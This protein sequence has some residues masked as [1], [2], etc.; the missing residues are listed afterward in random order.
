[1]EDAK[2]TEPPDS[3]HPPTNTAVDTP[4][5]HESTTTDLPVQPVSN[6]NDGE[7]ADEASSESHHTSNTEQEPSDIPPSADA[8][9][10]P[11]QSKKMTKKQIIA[12]MLAL[13]IA[14]F[15]AALDMSIVATAMPTIATQFHASE[16]GYSWIAS[17]YL[18]GNATCMPLWGKLSDIWGRKPIILL[19]NFLFLVSS[20][21]CAL[22]PNL[23]TL[24][25]GRAIQGVGGGGLIIL[26][27][28]CVGDLF[29]VRERPLYYAMF[30]MTWAVAGSFGP[31]VGGL[32]TE[33]VNWR[34]CFYVNLPF[35]GFSFATLFF[36][37]KIETPKTPL[38]AGLR[39]ID[40][41]GT[42]TII[43]GTLMV[44]FGLEFGGITFP[45][46]SATVICLL[47]FGLI[48][49][50]LFVVNE[51]RAKYPI[52]PMSLFRD[53]SNIFTLLVTWSHA[54]VFIS[55]TFYLPLYFQIVL[56]ASPIMS[57]VYI[58][59]QVISL[60]ILSFAV[61]IFIRK[62]GLFVEAIQFGM[63]AMTLGYGLYI[64]FKPYL[65]W[66]RLIIYQIISGI[67]IGP[68]FQSPLIAL[69][70]RVRQSE[71]AS[72]TTTHGFIRQLATSSS[73]VLGGVVYQNVVRQSAQKLVAALG[74]ELAG[75]FLNSI[76]NSRADKLGGL[77]GEQRAVVLGVY[78]DAFSRVWIFYT[79]ISG[80]GS[81]FSLF[82]R[83]KE[84]SKE[85]EVTRTGLEAQ[86]VAR[87]ERVAARR[88][89]KMKKR[90]ERGERDAAT[91]ETV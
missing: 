65:S 35:G 47:I 25:A 40:W 88:E 87:L 71:V 11:A 50:A 41:L 60:S 2:E 77:S 20:L 9:T 24:L 45:W 85:H 62:T 14:L 54:T 69:H 13:C 64:D 3:P 46:N 1:M 78:S 28:V 26:G 12:V 6:A 57:G 36:W 76:G 31:V 16:S 80:L 18:L 32:F 51:R 91:K 70:A 90:G 8:E 66:P 67:G 15:L 89:R 53:H 39:T 81:V 29:S 52:M 23:T 42:I 43:G 33:K 37:L 58:L 27:Q 49:M 82:I 10:G 55:G 79:A 73:V 84:L 34:W 59:P 22:A 5:A 68:N 17:A 72:V 63:L 75:S 74:P 19:A 38:L 83:R 44:L 7:Q 48:V 56:G 4:P 21:M 30:G 61:G 86:E